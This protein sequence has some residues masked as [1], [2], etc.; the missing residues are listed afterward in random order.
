MLKFSAILNKNLMPT[1]S[2]LAAD[3]IMSVHFVLIG[4]L[5]FGWFSRDQIVRRAH[6]GITLITLGFHLFSG[7]CPLWTLEASLRSVDVGAGF[8]AGHGL[9]WLSSSFIFALIF[10]LTLISIAR[11]FTFERLRA[12]QVLTG[13]LVMLVMLGYGECFVAGTEILM[14]DGS[15]KV[16]EKI[17]MGDIVLGMSGAENT[18][19]ELYQ[20]RLGAQALYSVN[21]GEYFVTKA[22]PFWTTQGWQAIDPIAAKKWNPS[23]EVDKLNTGDI[24]ILEN[25]EK[26]VVKNIQ[27]KRSNYFTAIYN[28]T[29]DGNQT[30]YADGYLVHNKGG[31]TGTASGIGDQGH[32]FAG[33]NGSNG[34]GGTA[35]GSVGG[36]TGGEGDCFIAGT[37]ITMANG[38][39]QNIEDVQVSELVQTVNTETMKVE[40]KPV[41]DL[42][43]QYHTGEED[44]FTIRMKFANGSENQNTNTHPYYVKNKGWSSYLPK[45]TLEKYG[46]VVELLEK[47]DVVY[48]LVDGDLQETEITE[49]EEIY[50]PVQ[51]YNLSS[52]ADNNNFFAEGILVHNKG[53]GG[54]NFCDTCVGI[55]CFDFGC[56]SSPVCVP[57]CSGAASVCS[58]QA[59]GDSCGVNSC[60]GTKD[61]TG[62]GPCVPICS[63]A[64]SVCSGQAFGDSCGVN[65]CTGTKDCTPPVF[66][67]SPMVFA[68]DDAKNISLSFSD[69]STPLSYDITACGQNFNTPSFVGDFSSAGKCDLSFTVCD[70]APPVN[71]LNETHPD[72]F[73]VVA[74]VPDW[75]TGFSSITSSSGT[76]IADGVS[77]HTVT[78]NLFDQ[79]S[80]PVISEAS[81]K[82]V[83]VNFNFNNTNYLDQI[84]GTGDPARYVSG[85][86]S[87][88]KNPGGNN[89]GWLTEAAGGDGIYLLQMSS[90]SPTSSDYIPI[91]NDNFDLGF[92]SIDYQIENISAYTPVGATAAQ[93]QSLPTVFAF[94]P[95]LTSTPEALVWNGS[96]YVSSAAGVKNITINAPKRFGI[97]LNNAND[98]ANVPASSP[99]LGIAFSSGASNIIWGASALEEVD[100]SSTTKDLV[101]DTNADL[102][103][104]TPGVLEDLS[105]WITSIA[106]DTQKSLRF[107]ATPDLSTTSTG[108]NLNTILQT[109]VCYD[110]GKSVCH[111]SEKLD[112]S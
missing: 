94:S 34:F 55:D 49:I 54:S 84:A 30:Y 71:C 24:L 74:N 83:K 70:S 32:G 22:H 60:T 86:F 101:L 93:V 12:G 92:T 23:L 8:W 6:L 69:P 82:N 75:N 40:V 58:G 67:S 91:M 90:Y 111:R 53:N 98:A 27:A 33:D 47:G 14:A 19:T 48:E 51:T 35:G 63:G 105:S 64:A 99:K 16:I 39:T 37:Q 110:N 87:L 97:N 2:T 21:D 18:V 41:L 73:R 50:E 72:F 11:N 76:K 104:N 52:V 81:I 68:A 25:A 107:Q 109:Y 79:Y 3:I 42:L 43:S 29:T 5:L 13:A 65:S 102:L 59:F 7:V 15:V 108:D 96:D 45:L 77:S 66:G 100:S 56:T 10:L 46:L 1:F 85:E 61:C 17:E 57:I 62:P 9:T 112:S 89:T 88:D 38:N 80:N 103:F 44:D 36:A 95:V 26:K 78:V 28:F 4:F 106:D 31:G 20:H